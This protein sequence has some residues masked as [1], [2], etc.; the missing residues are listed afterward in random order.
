MNKI[1]LNFYYYCYSL[2]KVEVCTRFWWGN[3]RERDHWG[4]QD[5][6]GRIILR[7]IFRKWE[8]VVG[9]GWGW[10]RIGTGGGDCEYGNEFRVPKNAGNFL[11]NCKFNRLASQER[12]CSM[13]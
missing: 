8:G 3:L 6:D 1:E 12:L 5:V 10:L 7:W 4:D 9:T 11:I 13:E 2:S